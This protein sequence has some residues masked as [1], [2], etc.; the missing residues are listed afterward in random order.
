M[1]L[2][3]ERVDVWAASIKDKPGALSRLLT[4]LR[5]AGVDIDFAIARRE[6]EKPGTGV[7]FV[8]PL[9]GDRE[10]AAAAELGFN[11]TNSLHSVRVEGD[12]KPGIGAELTGKLAD[13][14][15]NLRG[16]SA[17]V[18]GARFIL[19]MALDT[20]EDAASA[21]EILKEV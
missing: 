7:V 16:F 18:L 8:T 17:A 15:I 9:R 10:V 13:S 3:V 12:N 5:E 6:S 14:G 1:E 19:Y 20:A 21:M 4:G 2:I 11:V